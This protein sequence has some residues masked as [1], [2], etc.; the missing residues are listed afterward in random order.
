MLSGG[1]IEDRRAERD[2]RSRLKNQSARAQS[3]PLSGQMNLRVSEFAQLLEPQSP[4]NKVGERPNPRGEMRDQ[5]ADHPGAG[6]GIPQLPSA[7]EEC[8]L[9][10]R[11]NGNPEAL[12]IQTSTPRLNHRKI[13]RPYPIDEQ[14]FI[15]SATESDCAEDE[16]D[17]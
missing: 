2:D 10:Q 8:N 16:C 11:M 14:R 5:G 13:A 3:G 17:E 9:V 7:D 1:A 4:R 12:A 15:D 6:V